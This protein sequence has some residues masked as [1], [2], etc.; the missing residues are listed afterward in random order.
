M[1]YIYSSNIR[2]GQFAE[3]E[4]WVTTNGE[5]FA[6]V[7]PQSWAL[8]GFYITVFGLGEAH[9]EV[10]WEVE[11]YASLDIAQATAEE[12]GPFFELLTQMHSFLDPATGSARVL[13]QVGAPNSII[14]GC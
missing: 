5:R 2:T 11:R 6:S 10:H 12:K 8:K 9:V 14:V 7:Q 4:R 1:L 13:K 3:F